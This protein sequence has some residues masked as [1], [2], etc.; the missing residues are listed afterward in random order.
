MADTGLIDMDQAL[1]RHYANV[2]S[3]AICMGPDCRTS[4]SPE[5]LFCGEAC[6]KKARRKGQREL[7][8][9]HKTALKYLRPNS[10]YMG[11]TVAD[12]GLWGDRRDPELYKRCKHAQ[13]W[14]QCWGPIFSRYM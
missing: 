5:E 1:Q 2:D 8:K 7:P 9:T 13:E 14:R 6:F 4:I 11:A 12:G 3:K 10:A